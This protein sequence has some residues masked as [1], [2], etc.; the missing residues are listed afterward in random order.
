LDP[1]LV[2]G[3]SG[4]SGRLVARELCLLGVRP[5][6]CGRDVRKTEA[7]AAELGLAHRVARV[8]D[9]LALAAVLDGATVCVNA[10][11]PFT[12]TATPVADACLARGVHYLDLTGEVPVLERLA[13]LHAAARARGVMLMP[14]VVS[15]SCRRIAW[16]RTSPVASAEPAR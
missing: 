11:G 7:V 16:R 14:G 13:A 10:A 4:H 8:D 15:T 12:H 9:P 3:A 2:Y 1:V 6:L 5:V